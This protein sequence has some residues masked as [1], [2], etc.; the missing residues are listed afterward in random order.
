M[1]DNFG[2]VVAA[3]NLKGAGRYRQ[4]TGSTIVDGSLTQAAIDI[5]G[6][7]FF[8]NGSVT[9]ALRNDGGVVQGGSGSAPG[10][11]SVKGSFVQSVGGTLR[12]MI[13][14]THADQA[15]ELAIDGDVS[16]DG[17]LQI[18]T[19]NGFSFA[20][21]QVFT[22]AR[23]NAGTLTGSFSR[24]ADGNLVSHDGSSLDLG[25]NLELDVVYKVNGIE[26]RVAAVPEPAGS[27]LLLAGLGA[28]CLWTSRHPSL[29]RPVRA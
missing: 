2:G 12:E 13:V 17:V 21:G 20:A 10:L 16:L 19:A 6:G 1:F 4:S 8:G 24:I 28:I 22:I 18:V 27:A 3:G 29:R 25:G 7:N 14:G 5:E 9:G 11:L 23:M 15:S 26:L